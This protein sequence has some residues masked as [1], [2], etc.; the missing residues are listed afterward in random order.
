MLRQRCIHHALHLFVS[1]TTYHVTYH[2]SLSLAMTA[3]MNYS[4]YKSH[5]SLIYTVENHHHRHHHQ[6]SLLLIE[7]T[8]HLYKKNVM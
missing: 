4:L 2:L 1:N 8:V 5:W 6:D 7:L 3:I